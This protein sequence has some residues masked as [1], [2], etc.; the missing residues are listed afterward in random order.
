MQSRVIGFDVARAYA[1]LGMYIVNFTFCFGS[2][3]QESALSGFVSLFIGNSTAIFILCAG[4]G[5]VMMAKNADTLT[6]EAKQQVR[7]VMLKRSWFLFFAGIALYSW[8]PGD[9]LHFYGGY[10]HIA[11]LLLFLP[12]RYYLWAA[13]I[14][15]FGYYSLQFFLPITTSW[16]LQTTQYA[17]FW[18]PIGFLRNTLYN[19]WNSIFPW[20][21]YFALGMFLGKLD[22][23]N[24][25]TRRN[26]CAIGVALLVLFK[27]L[28]IFIRHD[29]NHPQRHNFY[30]KY[31]QQIFEDYFPV[32]I[33]YLMITIGFALIVITT[34]MHLGYAF[35]DSKWLHLLA[36]V[37]QM[38]L[39][40]YIIHTTFGFMLL[41]A[42]TGIPYTGYLATSPL[43]PQYILAY[44]VGFFVFS[45]LFSHFWSNKFAKGPAEMLM[46][47][48]SSK[49]DK[50]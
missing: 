36:K 46:R 3:R 19:G 21:A 50:K 25:R 4:M 6:A 5:A 30:M 31:S 22:W 26:L 49:N 37:G 13:A 42:L 27:G 14:A 40:H 43:E 1:I 39:S 2:F 35:P 32:T 18:T 41:Q 11:A 8:W 23:Q 45:V 48:F 33:P 29:F 15:I 28:R 10:L 12:K 9:I 38:T 7:A 34:C 24:P 17:D 44:S 16:N 20:F 47:A